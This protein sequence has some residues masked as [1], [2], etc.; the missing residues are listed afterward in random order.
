V[1]FVFLANV[2]LATLKILHATPVDAAVGAASFAPRA[3]IEQSIIVGVVHN[4]VSIFRRRRSAP[5]RGELSLRSIDSI[6]FRAADRKARARQTRPGVGAEAALKEP[7]SR[8]RTSG[9]HRLSP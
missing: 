8:T 7:A 5:G 4:Y 3:A 6:I 2:E 1:A 9:L